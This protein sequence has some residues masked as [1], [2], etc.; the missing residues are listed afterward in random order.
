[1]VEAAIRCVLRS[2]RAYTDAQVADVWANI[3][4]YVSETEAW[5]AVDKAV[6]EVRSTVG[7]TR[8]DHAVYGWSGGKD[9]LAL[10]VVMD[11][12]GVRRSVCGAIPHVEWHQY[13]AWVDEH[14]P[15]GMEMICNYDI[16][17]PWLSRPENARYLFPRDAK[18][19][20][21]WT[22]AGTRMA[23]HA[24]QEK[25]HPV[26]QIYGRRTADGNICGD[27]QGLAITSRLTS[28]CPL[29]A[30]PHEL[31]LAVVRYAGLPLPPVYDWPHGWTAG[32]GSWPGRRVG[33]YDESWAETWLIEP[34]RVREAAEHIP[35]ARLWLEFSGNR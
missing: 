13:L 35:G 8:L 6:A 26:V 10:Q 18:A 14:K 28:Y 17:V 2:K 21:F 25:H 15:D 7:L 34:D 16:T 33:S 12:A 19:G 11:R 20:Y 23:Q 29:R 22:L 27:A 32:T 31:V 3:T 9:S 5:D 30:W 1:M 24:Y 4:S